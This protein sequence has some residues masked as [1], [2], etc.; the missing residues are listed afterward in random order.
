MADQF[1]TVGE[2]GNNFD[3]QLARMALENEGIKVIVI[4]ENLDAIQPYSSLNPIKLQVPRSDAVRAIE[5]LKETP[6]PLEDDNNE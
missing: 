3:A 5:I 6:P 1:V 4:G 2:F